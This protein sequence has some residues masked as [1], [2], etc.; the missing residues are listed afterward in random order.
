[1][2]RIDPLGMILL[3][4]VVPSILGDEQLAAVTWIVVDSVVALSIRR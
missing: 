4:G 2:W 3:P 1:M